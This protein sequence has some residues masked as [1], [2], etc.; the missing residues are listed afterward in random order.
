MQTIHR[1]CQRR[2]IK[3]QPT[4]APRQRLACVALDPEALDV[5]GD[6]FAGI[7]T[8]GDSRNRVAALEA[9][10]AKYMPETEIH[11]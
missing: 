4:P 7:S 1:L 9:A 2:E 8:S 11:S 10:H 5:S 6:L 3:D